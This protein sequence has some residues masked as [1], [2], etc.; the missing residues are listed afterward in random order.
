MRRLIFFGISAIIVS[1]CASTGPNVH[2]D[3]K[4]PVTTNFTSEPGPIPTTDEDVT[5]FTNMPRSVGAERR[6]DYKL[7]VL[8]NKIQEVA[9]YE[10]NLNQLIIE[11]KNRYAPLRQNSTAQQIRAHQEAKADYNS[12][13]ASLRAE[14]ELKTAAVENELEKALAEIDA[15]IAVQQAELE[16]KRKYERAKERNRARTAKAKLQALQEMDQANEIEPVLS[17]GVSYSAIAESSAHTEATESTSSKGKDD[18]THQDPDTLSLSKPS[19]PPGSFKPDF[20]E[21]LAPAYANPNNVT[22]EPAGAHR[23]KYDAV[24][25]YHDKKTREIWFGYLHAYGVE[26]MFRSH[27]QEK[28]EY[29]IYLGTYNEANQAQDRLAKVEAKI[30]NELNARIVTRDLSSS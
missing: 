25:V 29:Y 9:S 17:E 7:S 15:R 28:G 1:G 6:L 18:A 12:R 13:I 27:N 22:V 3:L 11:S 21:Q 2:T 8:E 26:S 19:T 16:A 4:E 24:L 30:G 14:L 20:P 10:S 23:I 5:P